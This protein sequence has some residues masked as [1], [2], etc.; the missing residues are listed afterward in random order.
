MIPGST[1]HQASRHPRVN[2]HLPGLEDPPDDLAA[3]GLGERVD[4]FDLGRHGDRPERDPHM[5]DEFVFQFIARGVPDPQGNKRLDDVPLQGIR[6]PDHRCFCNRLVG[7]ERTLNFGRTDIV[8]GDNDQIVRP[9]ITMM[10][11][12]VSFMARSPTV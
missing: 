4:K 6:F 11:P 10:F 8:P 9:P 2:T 12:S 1:I 7:D 3:P 5:V